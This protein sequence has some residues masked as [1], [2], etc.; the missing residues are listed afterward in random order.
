MLLCLVALK[1]PWL[2]AP[3][4]ETSADRPYDLAVA[5]HG[6]Y[7]RGKGIR[8]PL[9]GLGPRNHRAGSFETICGAAH[10]GDSVVVVSWHYNYKKKETSND[11]PY[12]LVVAPHGI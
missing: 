11:R 6:I 7:S 3:K 12:D 5:P 1:P 9:N 10:E 8:T 4:K 2:V